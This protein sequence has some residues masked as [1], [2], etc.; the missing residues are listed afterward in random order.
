MEVL[1]FRL[2]FPALAEFDFLKTESVVEVDDNCST[3]LVEIAPET[4]P[5]GELKAVA[6]A[7]ERNEQLLRV[8]RKR[9][10]SEE[11]C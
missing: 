6:A 7:M 3:F 1:R 10:E 2:R 11:N 4:A 5:E 8:L 9:E